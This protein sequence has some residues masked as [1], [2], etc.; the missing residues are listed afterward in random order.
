VLKGVVDVWVDLCM[1]KCVNS[2]SQELMEM[3]LGMEVAL[4]AVVCLT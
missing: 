4:V 1:D 3:M 2:Y